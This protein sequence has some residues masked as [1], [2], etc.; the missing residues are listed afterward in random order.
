MTGSCPVWGES[1]PGLELRRPELA[2]LHITVTQVRQQ[3]LLSLQ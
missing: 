1:A 2:L 3:L